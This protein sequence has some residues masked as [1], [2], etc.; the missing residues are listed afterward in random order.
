MK[1]QLIHPQICFYDERNMS[2]LFCPEVQK[3]SFFCYLCNRL[4]AIIIF[5]NINKSLIYEEIIISIIHFCLRFPG[6][7]P[8]P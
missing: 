4:C 6:H 3:D 5:K 1:K 2:K 7:K 8:K